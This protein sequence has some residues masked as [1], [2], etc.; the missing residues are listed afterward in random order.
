MDIELRN[1]RIPRN[2]F[3]RQFLD[4][5]S[6]FRPWISWICMADLRPAQW[7][8]V[9]D[10]EP[11]PRRYVILPGLHGGGS[12]QEETSGGYPYMV[13]VLHDLYCQVGIKHPEMTSRTCWLTCFISSDLTASM[14]N[15]RGRE[16]S[17]AGGSFRKQLRPGHSWILSYTINALWAGPGE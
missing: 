13:H 11:D 1:D 12:G 4:M 9:L 17:S 7:Q 10:P 6:G 2:P 16:V 15:R 5:W 3:D 8:E 14:R